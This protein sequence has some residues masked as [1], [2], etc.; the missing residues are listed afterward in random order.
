[1][2]K[3]GMIEVDW[4]LVN[5]NARG[6]CMVGNCYRYAK[7]MKQTNGRYKP[8]YKTYC[9]Y[10]ATDETRLRK[11]GEL[12]EGIFRDGYYVDCK[13]IGLGTFDCCTKFIPKINVKI[14]GYI[15]E[16]GVFYIE[17]ECI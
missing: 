15:S 6:M 5:G 17:K 10:C 11:E 8:Y 2:L 9:K 7:Y 1:M 16:S 12:V 14:L 13:E 4:G 3:Q